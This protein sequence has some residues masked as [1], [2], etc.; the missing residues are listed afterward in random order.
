MDPLRCSSRVLKLN[1]ED[2]EAAPITQTHRKFNPTPAP[3]SRPPSS[4][5]NRLTKVHKIKSN[6]TRKR[7]KWNDR[8]HI[9]TEEEKQTPEP[10]S[11]TT[12]QAQK[13][14]ENSYS[15][16]HSKRLPKRKNKV[17]H[18][19]MIPPIDIVSGKRKWG[20]NK[21]KKRAKWSTTNKNK[22]TANMQRNRQRAKWK[23]P[24][25]EIKQSNPLVMLCEF[26]PTF[27]AVFCCVLE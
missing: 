17:S 10:P 2:N 9:E 5:G 3:I 25:Q 14:K 7:Y 1:Q 21:N 27:F 12:N 19:S 8:F 20:S 6:T 23:K 18:S 16:L 13:K 15:N 24:M 11:F 22:N 26:S 4:C